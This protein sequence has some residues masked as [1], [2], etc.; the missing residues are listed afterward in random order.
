MLI[1]NERKLC[2]TYFQYIQRKY[3]LG[4]LKVESFFCIKYGVKHVAVVSG[5]TCVSVPY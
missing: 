2:T 1:D 5:N 3:Y 4:Y